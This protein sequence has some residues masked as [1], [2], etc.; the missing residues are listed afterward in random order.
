ML[1]VDFEV[2]LET[3][4][5]AMQSIG[6]DL[7]PA[8]DSDSRLRV[9]TAMPEPAGAQEHLIRIID[10]MTRFSQKTII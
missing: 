10:E 7:N 2:C 4:V 9:L 6:L 8:L 5:G 1:S 3:L